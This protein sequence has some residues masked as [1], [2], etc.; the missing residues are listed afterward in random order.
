MANETVEQ[1]IEKHGDRMDRN[2]IREIFSGESAVEGFEHPEMLRKWYTGHPMSISKDTEDTQY[3]K[4][5]LFFS[6]LCEMRGNRGPDTF[7]RPDL[8]AKKVPYFNDVVFEP[9]AKVIQ[10]HED[11]GKTAWRFAMY[12]GNHGGSGDCLDG[13]EGES[14]EVKTAY[15]DVLE[16]HA[17]QTSLRKFEFAMKKS[18][19]G[20]AEVG[21]AD[22]T[23]IELL[24]QAKQRV[25]GDF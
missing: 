22:A 6:I 14:D 10:T 9:L 19:I 3:A 17:K 13:L 8:N 11:V 12:V 2:Y 1:L 24:Q 15:L 25:E 16:A 21:S 4:E 20:Y 23:K 18:V 7:G 5:H